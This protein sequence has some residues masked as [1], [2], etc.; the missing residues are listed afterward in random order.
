MKYKAAAWNMPGYGKSVLSDRMT[1]PDLAATLL[2]LLN[3]ASWNKVHLVGHSMGGMVAQEFAVN[4]QNRLHSLTLSATSPSF[5]SPDGKF[6]KKFVDARLGPLAEGKTMTDLATELVQTMMSPD[7]DPNGQ[8]LAF[9]C[10]SDVA[11]ETYRAAVECIVTFEQRANLPKIEVPTLVL[12][13][14][15]DTNAPPPM[16]E[17]MASKI[18]GARYVCLPGSAISPIS[19]TRKPLMPCLAVLLF[20]QPPELEGRD[21]NRHEIQTQSR[22]KP[23]RKPVA[24]RKVKS[25]K[26][27]N[28]AG[29]TDRIKD[30]NEAG[31]GKFEPR[32]QRYDEEASFPF[33]N[34][35]DMRDA[36]I[37][38]MTVPKSLG[39]LG[40]EYADYA[41]LAAEMG[42]WCGATA[43]TYKCMPARLYGLAIL[44]MTWICRLPTA[45]SIRKTAK[46]TS[47]GLSTRARFSPSHFPRDRRGC[48]QGGV[49]DDG[50]KSR[51]RLAS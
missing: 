3:E 44:R 21:G 8:Q 24:R 32:A 12:A 11:A 2:A 35:D 42:R 26:W 49:W 6:Q 48:G 19:M 36:G 13:G 10:M 16:M 20:P 47:A 31:A 22:P 30:V 39:G 27:Q 9:D 38:A 15:L 43:L 1:F 37:L 34:Y 41:L 33:E 18:P 40:V 7:A 23:K 4:H 14:E 50:D 5:G 51:W 29:D 28:M 17:K 45:S 25:F 46:C